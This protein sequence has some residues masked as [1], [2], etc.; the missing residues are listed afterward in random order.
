MSGSAIGR[1]RI[2]SAA[3]SCSRRGLFGAAALALSLGVA[4]RE[5]AG[6]ATVSSSHAAA[7]ASQRAPIQPLRIAGPAFQSG[8]LTFEWRGIS[9]FRLV[10][11]VARGREQDAVAFLDWARANDVTVV[12]V[13]AMAQHLFQLSPAD[14]LA[15]LPRLLELARDRDRRVEIVALVDTAQS[16]VDLEGHVRSVGAMAVKFSNAL[17]EV[18]NEPGHQTQDRRLHDP[19]FVRRLAALVPADVPVALG[20]AEYD[21]RFADGDY[22]TYHFPRRSSDDG[23][24]HVMAL[25]EGAAFVERWQKPV[26]SDEPIGAADSLQPG[27]RDND[28][29][30]FR[31]AAALTRLAG[32]HAT[33]HHEGGLQG[34]VPTGRELQCFEAWRGGLDLVKALPPGGRFVAGGDVAAMAAADGARAVFG[35]VFEREAW[36]VAVDPQPQAL[37]KLTGGWREDRRASGDGAL[38]V[39]ARR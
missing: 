18:A 38:V 12:R 31:A 20:S 3:R 2:R 28:P 37:T 34:R 39:Q 24:G 5:P 33:F 4:C 1:V 10:E 17:L 29:R 16:Q 21:P 27:R 14:G 13:F 6:S 25:A 35:R 9:A 23:W 19:A 11:M 22:A 15:A 30:R 26:V 8:A 7:T 36:L 32:L